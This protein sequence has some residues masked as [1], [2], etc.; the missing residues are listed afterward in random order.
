MI[1]VKSTIILLL[2]PEKVWM[3]RRSVAP[4][5]P[6]HSFQS[7]NQLGLSKCFI[8]NM[9]ACDSL[10][11]HPSLPPWEAAGRSRVIK[12]EHLFVDPRHWLG[13]I[14]STVDL[15]WRPPRAS[16]CL[17]RCPRKTC[18]RLLCA[19]SETQPTRGWEWWWWW[20]CCDDGGSGGG[21]GER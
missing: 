18:T 1:D 6:H 14:M 16:A 19:G 20:W 10:Y 13:K 9:H 11:L 17:S 4:Y 7:A 8:S 21:G 3:F 15:S 2:Q 12:H 5:S